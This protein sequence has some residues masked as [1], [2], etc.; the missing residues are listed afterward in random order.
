M[1]TEE[2]EVVGTEESES[3]W[4]EKGLLTEKGKVMFMEE[5]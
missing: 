1:G 5:E 3:Q 2:M 4:S